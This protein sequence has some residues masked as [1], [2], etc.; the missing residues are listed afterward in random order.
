[1][2]YDAS[3]YGSISLSLELLFRPVSLSLSNSLK[4]VL[5]VDNQ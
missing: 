4:G 3:K 2:A 5:L 1:L